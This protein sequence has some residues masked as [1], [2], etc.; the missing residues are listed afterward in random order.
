M[1]TEAGNSSE[2]FLFTHETNGKSPSG[3]YSGCPGLKFDPTGSYR[4]LFF[5]FLID[6]NPNTPF[7]N[8]NTIGSY[9]ASPHTHRGKKSHLTFD[10]QHI[11][12]SIKWRFLHSVLSFYLR[13]CACVCVCECVDT[14]WLPRLPD[15]QAYVGI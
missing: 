12:S 1:N 15:L 11:A 4:E 2:T 13:A 10:V 7:N 14:T 5:G 8:V 3:L 9:T 6:S